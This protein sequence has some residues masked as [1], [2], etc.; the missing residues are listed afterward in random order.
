MRTRTAV[1]CKFPDTRLY[2]MR[3]SE[4]ESP[5]I[6]V[7]NTRFACIAEL[8]ACISPPV[9]AIPEIDEMLKALAVNMQGFYSR[10]HPFTSQVEV[11]R[12]IYTRET[13]VTLTVEYDTDW[14]NTSSP[15][16][17]AE[18]EAFTRALATRPPP[19]VPVPAASVPAPRRLS[20]RRNRDS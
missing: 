16:L 20:L 5:F 15:A 11:R 14:R 8:V 9:R 12:L 2:R 13:Q 4:D 1:Y 10:E 19:A 18:A 7:T 6:R 3:N 17:T